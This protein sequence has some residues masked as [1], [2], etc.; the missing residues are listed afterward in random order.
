[1][2]PRLKLPHN[3]KVCMFDSSRNTIGIGKYLVQNPTMAHGGLEME[4]AEL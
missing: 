1:M 2:A 3:I 4:M